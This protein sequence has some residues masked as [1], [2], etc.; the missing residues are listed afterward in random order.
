MSFVP[1]M[2]AHTDHAIKTWNLPPPLVAMMRPEGVAD[3]FNGFAAGG[4]AFT[5]FVKNWWPL[6]DK[7][8]VLMMHFSDMKKDHAGAVKKIHDLMG[9][10]LN[11]KQLKN[12]KRLT[13]FKH[14]KSIGEVF[15]V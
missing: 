14:M 1:F 8:N 4:M 6:K 11:K 15:T 12:V 13:S 5:N 7:P 9:M 2:H 3:V 10:K